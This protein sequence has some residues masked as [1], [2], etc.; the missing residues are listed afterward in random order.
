[1][2]RYRQKVVT[3]CRYGV[4]TPLSCI[5]HRILFHA[6]RIVDP[7]FPAELPCLKQGDQKHPGFCSH[8]QIPLPQTHPP[9]SV[10]I[11][12]VTRVNVIMSD[13]WTTSTTSHVPFHTPSRPS[14]H[15]ASSS[16]LTRPRFAGDELDPED[17]KMAEGIKFLPSFASSP[18]GKLALGHG[19]SP[20]GGM[21]SGMAMSTSPAQRRSPTARF[22]PGAGERWV[23][24]PFT[25]L[26]DTM[27]GTDHPCSWS[28]NHNCWVPCN[29][30]DLT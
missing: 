30:F 7:C 4:Y 15:L 28:R 27:P 8:L 1:M 17:A 19:Q 26:D 14:H 24:S 16:A 21:G 22:T 2:H 12:S 9:L 18:A 10:A 29:A 20:V 3:D 25:A 13:W 6:S 5:S 11:Q 23:L